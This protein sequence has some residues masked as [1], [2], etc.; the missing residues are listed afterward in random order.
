MGDLLAVSV[1]FI[2]LPTAFG[3]EWCTLERT[4]V[5]SVLSLQPDIIK[6]VD[7]VDKGLRS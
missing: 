6:G 7:S 4:D 5:S 2:S 1:S 3:E